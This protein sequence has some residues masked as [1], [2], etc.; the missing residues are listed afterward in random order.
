M[1]YE[2]VHFLLVDD[3]EENLLA[4]EALLRRDGLTLLKARSGPEALELLLQYDAALALVDVQMPGMSGFELAEFMRGTERTKSVPIIFLTAGSA[5]QQRR[6]RGYEAGAMDF[7]QKPIEPDILRSKADVFFELHRRRQELARQR[8][9]L[10]AATEE[11]ARLLEESRR[12]AEALKEADQRKDEFLATLAHELRNPLAPIRNGL[13][14]LRRN[15]TGET[16]DNVRDMMDRQL[17]HMVRLIDDLLDMSRV[18]KGKIELRKEKTSLQSIIQSSLETSRPHI[19]EGRHELILDMPDEPIWVD[20]DITRLG[21]VVGNLLNNAAKYTPEGGK[22]RLLARAENDRAIVKV[23]DNGVGIPDH[24]RAKIFELFTQVKS[25]LEQSQGGL[26]IGLALVR[27]LVGMHGGTVHVESAGQN[28]G[29]TFTIHL[30]LADPIELSEQ[31]QISN[32]ENGEIKDLRILVVDDNVA[33]AKT[34]GWMLE[35]IGCQ[36]SLAHDGPQALDVATTLQPDV[37]LLDIGLPGMN[38]Y[39]VCRELRRNSLFENTLIIAQTGWGQK[40]D[41]E[42]A[43]EAGFNHHLVKPLNIDDISALLANRRPS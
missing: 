25:S 38:G 26:G 10:K 32:G 13:E 18:S 12:Y 21:Q 37:I 24:M 2:P 40:R 41:R 11:N 33:S 4:L 29:S 9:E 3:L 16:A 5:D 36:A 28:Q 8:D 23:I 42:M 43:R 14:I 17:A 39:E 31:K 6:F 35:L 34:T 7:L 1:P 30:P 20:A 22:I 15:P 27:H 19:E